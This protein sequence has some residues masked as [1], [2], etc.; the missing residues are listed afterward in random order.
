LI[1]EPSQ[2]EIAKG[3][4]VKQASVLEI[5]R[6]TDLYLSTLRRFVQAASWSF[7]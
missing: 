3:A 2:D 4:G 6:Q 1:A 5:E 7:G